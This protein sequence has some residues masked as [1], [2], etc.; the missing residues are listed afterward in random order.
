M[1]RP[2]P[3][4][5]SKFSAVALLGLM[6]IVMVSDTE[7]C[8]PRGSVFVCWPCSGRSWKRLNV[9]FV[10]STLMLAVTSVNP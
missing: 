5:M 10:N 9:P 2:G 8:G 6:I 7:A 1:I 3:F 4:R